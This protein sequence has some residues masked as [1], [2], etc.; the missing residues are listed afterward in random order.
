MTLD[1]MLTAELSDN[2][3]WELLIQLSEN[4]GFDEMKTEF[5]TALGHEEDHLQKVRTWLSECVLDSAEV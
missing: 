2:A 4:L 1:A 3:G 5:E